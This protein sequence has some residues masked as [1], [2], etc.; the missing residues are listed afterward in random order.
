MNESDRKLLESFEDGSLQSLTHADHVRVAYL[1][2]MRDPLAD[3]LRDFPAR[4]QS[5]AASKGAPEL[6]H[7]TIT[8][9]FIALIHERMSTEQNAS[10]DDFAQSNPDLLRSSVLTDD[11]Y[12]QEELDAPLARRVFVLPRTRHT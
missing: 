10:W 7:A 6:Y 5:Y 1:Y 2:L 4:L 3:V 11:Y 9:A 8:W 12:R